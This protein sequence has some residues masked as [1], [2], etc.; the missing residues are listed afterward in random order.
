MITT[1][2]LGT[3]HPH[4]R[5]EK[6]TIMKILGISAS[7]RNARFGIG[8]EKLIAE[9]KRIKSK[10]KLVEYLETQTKIRV[11][12]FIAAGRANKEPFD[13]I[14]KNL[15]KAKGDKGL[16]NSEASLA[17]GLWSAY[18]EGAEIVHT[19]LSSYFPMN[20][21]AKRL[22]ELKAKIL[23]ADALLISGPVYFGDRSSLAHEFV[24]FL[25]C[26]QDIKDHIFGK[27]Y[28]GIAV[29][30]KR[31]G[32]QETS[33]IYQIIDMSNL[34]MLAV[35]NSAE[36]TAQYGGT[37]LA[38]DVGTAYKDEYGLNTCMG[39]GA[40]LAKTALGLDQVRD[41][42]LKD[43]VQIAVWMVQD[44]S[45]GK[46][47]NYIKSLLSK[48]Q[49]DDVEFKIVDL[50]KEEIYR[51][52]ACDVC[53]TKVGPKEEYR[54]II[55]AKEDYMQ[56]EHQNIVN[57]DAIL[58]AGYSPVDK[59]RVDSVYQK[60]I[61]RTRYL[62][63]DDYVFTD[64]LIAPLVISEMNS[65]QNLHIRMLTSLIRH[66]TILHHPLL[67]FEQDGQLLNNDFFLKQADLF[68][69]KAVQTT[70]ARLN[71]DA[72]EASK[73]SYNPIGYTIS[74]EQ[75]H[76][77]ENDGKKAKIE[78]VREQELLD[79]KQRVLASTNIKHLSM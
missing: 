71:S 50:S 16:S 13:E 59:T 61:E 12:D 51:C 60:F 65:N 37:T 18:Q 17:A 9:I 58:I 24:E 43:K 62:R 22:D 72:N 6:E 52:I 69:K 70:I 32:G 63:R 36:T 46:G 64:R 55:K 39:T 47:L 2:L 30:A 11:T 1:F 7:L 56:R 28:A 40:R 31:N 41:M 44:T 66:H 78:T 57:V 68:A 49:N 33:L 8:S 5:N 4:L 34:N 38:G 25:Q 75:K 19:S 74:M 35:G 10:E 3:L 26:D 67:A 79:E 14:Y 48:V 23:D 15:L 27:C 29:G 21:K 20:G 76:A 45:D 42:K 54:C 53:P 73:I 77:N